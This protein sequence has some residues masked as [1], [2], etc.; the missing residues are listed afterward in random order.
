MRRAAI[1][2]LLGAML[3][4]GLACGPA[5]AQMLRQGSLLD[6]FVAHDQNGAAVTL[7]GLGRTPTN[8]Q[9]QGGRPRIV[10]LAFVSFDCNPCDQVNVGWTTLLSKWDMAKFDYGFAQLLVFGKG[11]KPSTQDDAKAWAK[12]S[13]VPT[14]T[15]IAE[16]TQKD[17]ERLVSLRGFNFA[18]YPVFV[19]VGTDQRVQTVLGRGT[20]F[21]DL[22]KAVRATQ[23][24]RGLGGVMGR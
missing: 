4:L 14:R 8:V 9:G 2:T 23:P 7:Q 5:A 24:K 21:D 12:A 22:D 20:T 3:A 13:S 19:I 18:N 11:R 15:V 1:G 16:T 10:V 17:I 6:N